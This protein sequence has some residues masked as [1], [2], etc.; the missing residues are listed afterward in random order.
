M[1]FYKE[2]VCS[3]ETN[4]Y[5]YHRAEASGVSLLQ[6]LN[7]VVDEVLNNIHHIRVILATDAELSHLVISYISGYVGFHVIEPR[8]RISELRVPFLEG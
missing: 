5:V 7:D 6:C 4:G 8:Y 1:S 3:D 2:S